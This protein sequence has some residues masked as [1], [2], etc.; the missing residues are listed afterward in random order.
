MIY[1]YTVCYNTP[2][3]IEIQYQSLKKNIKDDFEYIVFNNTMTNTTISQTNINNNNELRR[4]CTKYNITFYD[5]PKHIFN[6]YKSV[7]Y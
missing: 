2:H 3:F 4:I 6:G 1:I 5:L 7:S